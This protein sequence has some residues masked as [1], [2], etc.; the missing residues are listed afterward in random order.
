MNDKTDMI[1]KACGF[2]R[3]DGPKEEFNRI[4]G[5][6]IDSM[7]VEEI[8]SSLYSEPVDVASCDS[9]KLPHPLKLSLDVCQLIQLN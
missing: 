9:S 1:G 2:V 3:Y 4:A 8:L 5:G 7:K 6:I